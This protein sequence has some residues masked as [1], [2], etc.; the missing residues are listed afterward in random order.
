MVIVFLSFNYV[1]EDLHIDLST[2]VYRLECGLDEAVA[3]EMS[4][5]YRSRQQSTG[6]R[7]VARDEDERTSEDVTSCVAE[8]TDLDND[9]SEQ[10]RG[11]VGRT[12]RR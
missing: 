8:T 12:H 4:V 9:L 5:S 10:E 6:A 7:E 1:Y 11:E 3:A 2:E